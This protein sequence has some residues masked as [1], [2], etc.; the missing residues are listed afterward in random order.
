MTINIIKLPPF[1]VTKLYRFRV[2][3]ILHNLFASIVTLMVTDVDVIIN[4]KFG[5]NL[6]GHV[7]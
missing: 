5:L 7:N 2:F 1:T 3:V 6:L 4:L